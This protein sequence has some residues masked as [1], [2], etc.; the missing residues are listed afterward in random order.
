MRY[1]AAVS[2]LLAMFSISERAAS[3]LEFA[4]A[5]VRLTNT[6][7]YTDS[8]RYDWTVSVMADDATLNSIKQVEYTLHPSFPN[9]VRTV[10]DRKSRFALSSNGWG[11]FNIA[12]R[13]FFDDGSVQNL[14]HWLTL[15]ATSQPSPEI[16]KS[17]PHTHGA[18]SAGNIS[19]YAGDDR[20]DWTVFLIS[21]NKTLDDIQCVDY[22]LHPTFP[23]PVRKV[24]MRGT[25]PGQGFFLKS[26]GWGTFTIGIRV[27]FRDGEVAALTHTLT[28]AAK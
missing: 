14:E 3:P 1:A 18:V 9:P 25:S 17:P 22:T 19:H 27:T 21:D 7:R 16:A 4:A 13:V 23:D 24:C 26:N 12:A 15:K 10:T 6:A 28:F 11:E 8:G 20:W 5:S 2:L